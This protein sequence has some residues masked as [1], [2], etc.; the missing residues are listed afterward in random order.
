MSGRPGE[1]PYFC[2]RRTHRL[3]R[4]DL[5]SSQITLLLELRELRLLCQDLLPPLLHG[6]VH[7]ERLALD[8]PR[9]MSCFLWM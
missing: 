4:R 5:F 3:S 1:E 7:G 8:R 9:L 6:R 2:G